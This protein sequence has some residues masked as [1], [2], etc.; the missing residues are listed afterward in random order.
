MYRKNRWRRWWSRAVWVFLS[1]VIAS[2]AGP[3]CNGDGD[4]PTSPD[5]GPFRLTF[6]L[7]STFQGPH[8]GQPIA[9]ALLGR[10][11]GSV[12]LGPVNGTVSATQDPSFTWSTGPVM[13]AGL[14]YEVHYWIDSNDGGGTLGVCDPRAND[15]QGSVELFSVFND[16]NVSLSHNHAVTEDVC[17]TFV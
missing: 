3:G 4:S 8:G 14:D 9:I 6:S 17:G 1:L 10:S 2:A 13:Q 5:S 11:D 7:D 15:H 16:R 12:I